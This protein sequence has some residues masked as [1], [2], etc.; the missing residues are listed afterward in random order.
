MALNQTL[1]Y[2]HEELGKAEAMLD[3]H[4]G[5]M[6]S[7]LAEEENY[8]RF[9]EDELVESIVKADRAVSN[10]ETQ[11]FNYEQKLREVIKGDKPSEEL[12]EEENI[13]PGL[14]TYAHL[15]R[16]AVTASRRRDKVKR[17]FNAVSQI[18]QQN[19][20]SELKEQMLEQ[21]PWHEEPEEAEGFQ[22]AAEI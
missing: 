3:L 8:Q 13:S 18:M 19:D 1:E 2:A 15:Y 11:F 6:V 17:Q 4:T 16:A 21:H 7:H 20:M 12:V 10:A 5:E 14:D 22:S 9:Y